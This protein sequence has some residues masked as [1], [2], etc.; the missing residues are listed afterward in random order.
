MP[1]SSTILRS[2]PGIVA[3]PGSR[4]KMLSTVSAVIFPKHGNTGGETANKIM[5]VMYYH[6]KKEA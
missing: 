1:L 2:V 4:F 3:R 6:L 5:E